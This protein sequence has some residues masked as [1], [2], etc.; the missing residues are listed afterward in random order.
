MDN[1]KRKHRKHSVLTFIVI[2]FIVSAIFTFVFCLYVGLARKM[3]EIKEEYSDKART[4]ASIINELYVASLIQHRLV[5]DGVRV[6]DGMTIAVFNHHTAVR[7][8]THH[9]IIGVGIGRVTLKTEWRN[10]AHFI[11][12][13]DPA[14][15]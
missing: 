8:R 2:V 3:I 4:V 11:V 9:L 7:C 12:A 15:E 14:R 6:G 10:N 13:M 5:C 1:H